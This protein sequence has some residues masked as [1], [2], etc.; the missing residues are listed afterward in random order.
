[1]FKQSNLLPA[2][3]LAASLASISIGAGAQGRATVFTMS[4]GVAGNAILAFAQ[5]ANGHLGPAGSYST[6]GVATGGG[7]GN[8]GSIAFDGEFLYA[9]N[10]GSNDLSCCAWATTAWNSSTTYPPAASGQS[11]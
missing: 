8:Q 2:A 9:V 11:A 6:G 5:E 10:A 3:A 7:L 4:N 1:M